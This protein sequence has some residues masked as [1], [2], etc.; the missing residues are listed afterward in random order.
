MR[1]LS[2]NTAMFFLYARALHK[3]SENPTHGSGW[4]I[5]MHSS[6][7]TNRRLNPTNGSWWIVQVSWLD[8]I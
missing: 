6:E 1:R 7:T 5:Q 8:A 4:I 3:K 2:I